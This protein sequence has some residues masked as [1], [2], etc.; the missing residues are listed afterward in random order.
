MTVLR[1]SPE[2]GTRKEGAGSLAW[3][4]GSRPCAKVGKSGQP[5]P[6]ARKAARGPWE[7]E[8]SPRYS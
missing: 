5:F 8:K 2:G 6:K 4:G 7:E 3:A 1:D